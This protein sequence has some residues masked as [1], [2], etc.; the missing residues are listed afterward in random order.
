ML[1]EIAEDGPGAVVLD[2]VGTLIESVPPVA[3]TY[4]AAARRQGLAIEVTQV[5]ARFGRAFAR[6]FSQGPLATH[7]WEEERC[8]RRVVGEVLREVPDPERAFAELWEHF[9]RPG[10]WR[11]FDDVAPL[12]D[13][14]RDRGTVVR[15]GSNFDG[16]LRTVVAGLGVV[17]GL[18]GSLVISSEVGWRKP[19]PAFFEAV[20]RDLGLAP[21]QVLSVG[22]D[23][24]NDRDGPRRLGMPTFWVDRGPSGRGLAPLTA[25]LRAR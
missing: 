12:L 8:W 14:L 18:A 9:G 3:E 21:G 4:A 11:V 20:C 17:E 7:E 16:R 25:W 19:H 13:V 24:E 23:A 6:V 1:E 15:V 2:A 10:S 5:R 22:D